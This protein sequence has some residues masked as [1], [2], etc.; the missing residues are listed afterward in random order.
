MKLKKGQCGIVR[1]GRRMCISAGTGAR[2]VA[3]D[4][5]AAA[6]GFEEVATPEQPKMLLAAEVGA[7][8]ID[9]MGEAEEE[10]KRE[11]DPVSLSSPAFAQAVA[12]GV[13]NVL[14][15]ALATVSEGAAGS[16]RTSPV[17]G[18]RSQHSEGAGYA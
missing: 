4:Y 1:G 16:S 7:D 3:K 9:D 15:E 13:A 6:G 14:R 12:T 5:D 8:H 11:L 18:G 2:F 10:L 17:T